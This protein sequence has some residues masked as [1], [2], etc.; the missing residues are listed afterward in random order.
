MKLM[1]VHISYEIINNLWSLFIQVE[2][3]KQTKKN[4]HCSGA[5]RWTH[6]PRLHKETGTR[7]F[8]RIFMVLSWYLLQ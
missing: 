6:E 7:R 4:R 5:Q 8:V 3:G 2:V 1:V